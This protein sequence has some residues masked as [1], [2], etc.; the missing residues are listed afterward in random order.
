MSNPFNIPFTP[1]EKERYEYI[2]KT[3]AKHYPKL[4]EDPV[5]TNMAEYLFV[6]FARTGSLPDAPDGTNPKPDLPVVL[7]TLPAE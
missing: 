6:Y 7:E 1:E 2:T 4:A 5:A 3:V